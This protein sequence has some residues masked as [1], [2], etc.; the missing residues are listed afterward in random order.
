MTLRTKQFRPSVHNFS[1]RTMRVAATLPGPSDS[2]DQNPSASWIVC[3]IF[4]PSERLCSLRKI[5]SIWAM[6]TSIK[7]QTEYKIS[8]VTILLEQLRF[9][10]TWVGGIGTAVANIRKLAKQIKGSVI[11]RWWTS[12]QV[13]CSWKTEIY[14]WFH[15][16]V[17]THS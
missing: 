12:F 8:G 15:K 1:G 7:I 6:I 2:R 9:C 17:I 4:I 5:C 16:C 14:F 11:Y 13:D 10:L 3:V